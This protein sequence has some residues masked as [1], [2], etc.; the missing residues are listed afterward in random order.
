MKRL[1]M[2][3]FLLGL[4]LIWNSSIA[5]AQFLEAG[6]QKLENPELNFIS[7]QLFY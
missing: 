2:I 3:F 4:L 1:R 5:T 6:V 7:F